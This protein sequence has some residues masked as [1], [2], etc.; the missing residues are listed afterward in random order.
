MQ[1]S[2][3]RASQADHERSLQKLRR[4]SGH[5]GEPILKENQKIYGKTLY[6]DMKNP[7]AKT[8]EM[9]PRVIERGSSRR[10]SKG[11]IAPLKSELSKKQV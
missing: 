5:Y 10:S 6:N 3:K 1:L 7:Y 9:R 8:Q 4:E 2:N 11:N